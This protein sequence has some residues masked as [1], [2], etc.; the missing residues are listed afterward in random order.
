[1][2]VRPPSAQR[3]PGYR[4][5]RGSSA[6]A[7]V[8]ACDVC[9]CLCVLPTTI[10]NKSPLK[11]IAGCRFNDPTWC[12]AALGSTTAAAAA[13]AAD[14]LPSAA[15]AAGATRRDCEC[16][17]IVLCHQVQCEKVGVLEN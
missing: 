8:A 9:L 12:A 11:V 15:A 16:W 4:R 10:S 5:R 1:M 14:S 6:T 2:R 7:A 17:L 13:A 3:P